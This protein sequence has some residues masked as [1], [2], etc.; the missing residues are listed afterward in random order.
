[1]SMMA[2]CW[3]LLLPCR[4]IRPPLMSSSEA[5]VS[6]VSKASNG[7]PMIVV[8]ELW[9]VPAIRSALPPCGSLPESVEGSRLS[10]PLLVK[11]PASDKRTSYSSVSV[12]ALVASEVS[13]ELRV[14]S[15]ASATNAFGCS[16][17]A[18][19]PTRST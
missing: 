10:V 16:A 15:L 3:R 14:V 1:M 17:S 4:L 7:L 19:R 2:R 9:N 13:A 18:T 6:T 11:S 12:P 8:P 5:A